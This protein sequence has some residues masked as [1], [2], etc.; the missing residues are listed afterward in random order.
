[1][2]RKQLVHLNRDIKFLE[3]FLAFA[4]DNGLNNLDVLHGEKIVPNTQELVS[5]HYV[6][7]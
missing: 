3:S 7:D 4:D 5:S 6:F 1:M 2:K